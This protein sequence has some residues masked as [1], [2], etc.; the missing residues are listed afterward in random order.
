MVFLGTARP[1]LLSAQG[2]H[3]GGGTAPS[4][5]TPSVSPPTRRQPDRQPSRPQVLFVS[6]IVMQEDGSPI[7]SGV[8]IERTC[9]GRVTRESYAD[10]TGR[11]SFQIGG[12]SRAASILP[13]A[14][15]ES[16]AEA[17]LFG[18]RGSQLSAGP[19]ALDRQASPSLMGCEIR[20]R[21]AG[22]TSTRVTIDFSNSVGNVDL[23]TILLCRLSRVAGTL[24]SATDLA[25][26]KSARKE[27]ARFEETYR[28]KDLPAAERHLRTA[29]DKYPNYAA[30]WF[31]LGQLYG[32]LGRLDDARTALSKAVEVDPKYVGPYVHLARL[33]A[34]Q[35]NWESA[36]DLSARAI[37]LDPVAF[38]D[39]YYL[40]TAANYYLK[41]LEAAERSGKKTA[42]MDSL[43]RIPQVHLILADICQ[44]RHDSAG[45]VEQ[46]QRYLAIAPD[47][48]QAGTVREQL[49]NMQKDDAARPVATTQPRPE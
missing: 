16:G 34:V 17:D 21:L 7:P 36:A 15:D 30:A 23:G 9:G 14:S 4:R 32:D 1:G 27:F 33:A 35:Q 31:G 12:T 2:S 24:V 20:A 45:A 8:V 26:P 39:A 22:Y 46:L 11:F 43:H 49:K 6:G 41:R 42:Q 10:S 47:S 40:N 28:K 18:G 25:A 29:L 13:D 48:S 44:R 38:V 37:E 3:K 19:T 5:T